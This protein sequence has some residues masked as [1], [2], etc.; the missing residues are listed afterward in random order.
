MVWAQIREGHLPEAGFAWE[1]LEN[2]KLPR[3]REVGERP[4]VRR[5]LRRPL[6][7]PARG[8]HEP[9]GWMVRGLEQGPV[10]LRRGPYLVSGG[11]W[12]REVRREYHFLETQRGDVLWV[13]YDRRRRRWFLHGEVL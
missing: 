10:I 8:R 7:L 13:F 4:L 3:P 9:D 6:A 1:P 11:W 5:L 2:A 12:A